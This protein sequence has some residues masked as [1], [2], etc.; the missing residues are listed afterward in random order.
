MNCCGNNE[1]WCRKDTCAC[2]KHV[3][4][5]FED[6]RTP[7]V[8]RCTECGKLYSTESNQSVSVKLG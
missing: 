1:G 8:K 5:L 6:T 4:A 3:C 7:G 2:D